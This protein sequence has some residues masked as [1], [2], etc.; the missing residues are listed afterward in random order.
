MKTKE[1]VNEASTLVGPLGVFTEKISSKID[2]HF[3]PVSSP[4]TNN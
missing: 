4:D 3:H 1:G 2:V